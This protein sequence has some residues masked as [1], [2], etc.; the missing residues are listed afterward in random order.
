MSRLRSQTGVLLC[1]CVC[2][3]VCVC[4]CVHVCVY[5]CVCMH[6]IMAKQCD[7]RQYKTTK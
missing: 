1:V 7:I 3:Y 6:K 4:M 2:V 5:V